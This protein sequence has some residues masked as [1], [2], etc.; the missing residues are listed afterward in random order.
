MKSTP[1]FFG[2]E[3]IAKTANKSRRAVEYALRANEITPDA[4]VETPTGRRFALFDETRIERLK[5]IFN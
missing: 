1:K 2:A 4:V 3:T 5:L